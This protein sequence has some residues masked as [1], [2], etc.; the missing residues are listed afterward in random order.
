[1]SAR[2]A[3]ADGVTT[4]TP[5]IVRTLRALP[6]LLRVGFAGIVA[7]RSEM[8][9]W[10]LTTNMPLVMLALLRAVA[11]EG[12]V[13]HFDAARFTAYYFAT[14]VVRL[15]TS[16]WVVWELVYEI[17]QGTLAAKLL[18]PLSPLVPYATD[19]LAALPIRGAMVL[20]I[21]VIGV[22][23]AGPDR[24]THD[25][26]AW[27]A[28]VVSVAAAWG[29]TFL[30]MLAIGT[31]ALRWESSLSLYNLWIA[32]YFVFSGY[33][34]PLELFPPRVLAVVRWMPFR[35]L[36]SF[37]VEI[38]L[39]AL[40]RREILLGL[41]AQLA[42]VVASALLAKVVWRDGLRRFAAYGG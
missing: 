38:A 25:P 13:G 42:W 12:P 28:F 35:Y 39:G 24:F 19:N 3:S 4:R 40:S 27:L 22:L 26:L 32:A 15:L 1:V 17:R 6:V 8:I 5:E 7:Y 30:V 9:V 33:L 34:L 31:L 41:A 16:A 37:P 20:P 2:P 23:W 14:L 36:L 18:R 11:A 10:I 21:A 29:V